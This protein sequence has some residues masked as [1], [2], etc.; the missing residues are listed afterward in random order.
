MAQPHR[1]RLRIDIHPAGD[2]EASC[3]LRLA[4]A[5]DAVLALARL[6]GRQMAREQ[7]ERQLRAEARRRS[8]A[9]RT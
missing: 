9:H 3:E 6:I 8:P 4:H 2:D 5:D 1:N 7:F